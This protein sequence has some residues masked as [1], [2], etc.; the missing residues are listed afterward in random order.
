[1]RP[2]NYSEDN[3]NDTNDDNFQGDT[4]VKEIFV[5]IASMLELDLC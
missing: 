3:G 5:R 2:E 4:I 1:M